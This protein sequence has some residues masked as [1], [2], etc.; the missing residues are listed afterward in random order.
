MFEPR[1]RRAR[2]SKVYSVRIS[3]KDSERLTEIMDKLDLTWPE[4][5]KKA[6]R[7]LVERVERN[8]TKDV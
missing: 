8:E 1:S 4:L 7:E 3:N 5:V 2:D 6:L